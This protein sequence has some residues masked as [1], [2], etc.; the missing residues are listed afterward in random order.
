MS[1]K[2]NTFQFLTGVVKDIYGLEKLLLSSK[3]SEH[4]QV[5]RTVLHKE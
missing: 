2:R 4:T 1:K 3:D 5:A